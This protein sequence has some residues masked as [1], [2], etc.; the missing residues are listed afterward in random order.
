MPSRA[1]VSDQIATN[2]KITLGAVA[3]TMDVSGD[4]QELDN[5]TTSMMVKTANKSTS[6]HPLYRCTSC[7]KEAKI[8]N[9]KNHIEANHLE[10]I[11]IPCNKCDKTFRSRNSL[12]EH[13][14]RCH[15]RSPATHSDMF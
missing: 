9:L 12:A 15:K 2:H 6:G 7:G 10:G 5:Q 8:A 11:L 14:Y 1:D 4:L 13:R 3:L